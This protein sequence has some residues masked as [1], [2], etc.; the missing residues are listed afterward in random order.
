MN[1]AITSSPSPVSAA[2][3]M[4][5]TVKTMDARNHEFSDVPEDQNVGDFKARIGDTVG[6]VPER[7]RIIYQGRV[8]KD[9]KPLKEYGVAD[10]KVLHLVKRQPPESA[11]QYL[12]DK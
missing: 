2:A 1:P 11:G 5:L 12:F 10:G 9:D 4:K 6:I 3:N 8:M 7:Q